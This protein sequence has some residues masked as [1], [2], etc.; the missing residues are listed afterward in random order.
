[1]I[2]VMPCIDEKALV[3]K[4]METNHEMKKILF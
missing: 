1:M 3:E 4:L 2:N